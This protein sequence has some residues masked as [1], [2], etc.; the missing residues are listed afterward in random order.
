[1]SHVKPNRTEIDSCRSQYD[2]EDKAK[3]ENIIRDSQSNSPFFEKL[4][5]CL[6]IQFLEPLFIFGKKRTDDEDLIYDAYAD[7]ML[8]IIE[9][10]PK[11]DT[12]LSAGKPLLNYAAGVFRIKML[13]EFKRKGK[14]S[15][16]LISDIDDEESES[17][18]PDILIDNP[19]DVPEDKVSILNEALK[20]LGNDCSKLLWLKY[21]EEKSYEDIGKIMGL[22]PGFLRTV[23]RKR[24]EDELK[25]VLISM[26][27]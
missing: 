8:I 16:L 13:E 6:L 3:N 7:T 10:L 4:K 19:W 1:M 26:N 2:I 11:I 18:A 5:K 25:K 17:I 21:A 24:C 20:M 23:K 9:Q 15:E 12:I 27:F 14:T 22:K